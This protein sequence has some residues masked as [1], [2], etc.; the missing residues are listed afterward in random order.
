MKAEWQYF[1][2]LPADGDPLPWSGLRR[3]KA[4]VGRSKVRVRAQFDVQSTYLRL[5]EWE[6]VPHTAWVE[7][8]QLADFLPK[9]RNYQP[10]KPCKGACK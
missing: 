1:W 5:N 2:V 4:L 7:G 3:I 9:L 6:A 8:E 10:P